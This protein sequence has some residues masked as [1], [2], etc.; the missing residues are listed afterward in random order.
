MKRIPN[1]Q[2]RSINAI[3][4][5]EHEDLA[6]AKRVLTVDELGNPINS[7][8]RLPVDVIISAGA[9][10]PVIVN[11]PVTD[12]WTEVSYA[13]AVN[14]NKVSMRV[15][16]GDAKIQFAWEVGK[17][18]TEFITV[19]MG[20]IEVIEGVELNGKT[21]YFQLSKGNKVVEIM[22]YTH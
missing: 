11:V 19:Q 21:L 3:H 16:G 14:T 22:C 5:D 1:N 7:S 13:F 9:S 2:V 8:N 12:A 4:Q 15:R 10:T 18:G 6:D 20:N 17:S